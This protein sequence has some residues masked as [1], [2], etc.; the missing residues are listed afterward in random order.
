M[1]DKQK[2]ELDYG[3][4][5]QI[6]RLHGQKCKRCASSWHNPAVNHWYCEYF[7]YGREDQIDPEKVCRKFSKRR[8]A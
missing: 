8:K 2:R 1:N 3:D 6:Q 4:P 5:N 7:G